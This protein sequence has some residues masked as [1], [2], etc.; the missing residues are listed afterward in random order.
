MSTQAKQEAAVANARREWL[1]IFDEQLP[2]VLR[3]GFG[4]LT[5]RIAV[6]QGVPKHVEST[7]CTRKDLTQT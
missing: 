7:P 2:A 6:F 3:A 4:E 1:K 5:A